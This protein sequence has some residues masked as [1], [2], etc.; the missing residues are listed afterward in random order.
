QSAGFSV[1]GPDKDTRG[2]IARHVP[3]MNATERLPFCDRKHSR[4]QSRTPSADGRHP[5]SH[6]YVLTQLQT[7]PVPAAEPSVRPER[8]FPRLEKTKCTATNRRFACELTRNQT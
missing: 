6:N 2:S 4:G 1:R 3:T 5:C 8:F 7:F